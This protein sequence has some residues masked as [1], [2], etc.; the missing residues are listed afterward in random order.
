MTVSFV[1]T[2]CITVSSLNSFPASLQLYCFKISYIFMKTYLN[3]DR[4][5]V[6]IV[7]EHACECCFITEILNLK[8]YLLTINEP[9]ENKGYSKIYGVEESLSCAKN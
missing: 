6:I 7:R 2:R 4:L 3:V 8:T 9:Y 5:E 1:N